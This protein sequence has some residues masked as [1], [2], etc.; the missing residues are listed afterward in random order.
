M[1]DCKAAEYH[2]SKKHWGCLGGM[3]CDATASTATL[4]GTD[5]SLKWGRCTA[6]PT[7]EPTMTPTEAPTIAPT[8]APTKA[9][10]DAG[11]VTCEFTIDNEVDQVWVDGVDVTSTVVGNLGN[12]GDKK[13]VSF[14][15]GESGVLAIK[16]RDYEEGCRN[17]GLAVKCTSGSNT[18]SVWNMNS[19]GTGRLS[20]LVPSARNGYVTPLDDTNEKSWYEPGYSRRGDFGVPLDGSTAYADG[21]IGNGDMCGTVTN[22][23]YW[24]F[25]FNTNLLSP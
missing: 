21:V 14:T 20:W 10:V 7:Q 13:T 12:W 17:G 15:S 25:L 11:P 16:G 19:G 3:G 24:H 9:P 4:I 2:N 8:P 1:G 18:A 5:H 22:E 23:Q 6:S